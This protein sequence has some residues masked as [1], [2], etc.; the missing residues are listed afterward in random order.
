MEDLNEMQ[1]QSVN[2]EETVT[3]A[4]TA[5][6]TTVSAPSAAE[7]DNPVSDPSEPIVT[8]DT[9]TQTLPPKHLIQKPL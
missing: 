1:P 7:N 2:T 6:T 9:P 4:S 8:M 3:N 5:S